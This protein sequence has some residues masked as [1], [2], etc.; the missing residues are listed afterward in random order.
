MDAV[1]LQMD[2]DGLAHTV[3]ELAAVLVEQRTDVF[4]TDGVEV[5]QAAVLKF[6]LDV[7]DA[8]AV[9]DG[10]VDLHRLEG[11]VAPFLFRPGV[12]GAHVVQPVAQLD[13]HDA[14]VLAHGQQHLAQVFGLA[15]LDVGEGDLGQLGDA[16]HKQRDL[17]AELL[18]DLVD[19]DGGVLG[20]IV[21]EGG[22]HALAVHA[23]L[24]QDARDAERVADIWFA[25][26]AE[27]AFVRGGG[28]GIGAVDQLKVIRA[29]AF[30]HL[31]LELFIGDGHSLLLFHG[32]FSPFGFTHPAAAP[33]TRAA[34]AI[35]ARRPG[36]AWP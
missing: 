25:A 12:A 30:G 26:A 8:E 17:R 20:H 16:V 32:G 4:V 19:A 18:A 3:Q 6:F 9:R 13:D 34:S 5:A 11:F 36:C 2:A 1:F 22:R 24:D 7:G 27:L 28:Q 10:G 15:V 21:H 35:P 33:P 14:H 23:E 31:L 29:A